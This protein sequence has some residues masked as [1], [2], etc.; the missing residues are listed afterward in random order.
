MW[1]L[2]VALV[3]SVGVVAASAAFVIA[4]TLALLRSFRAAA[5]DVGRASASVS[6][7]AGRLAER[8]E[9]VG[10]TERLAESLERFRASRARLRV[11][12][13]AWDDSREA[14]GRITAVV[15]RK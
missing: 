7:A 5:D 3:V 11:L 1:L 8:A 2:L 4:R 15:P 6:G 13:A 14:V 10:D 9:K 12:L